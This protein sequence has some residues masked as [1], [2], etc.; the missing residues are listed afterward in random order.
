MKTTAIILLAGMSTR[1]NSS[2]NK[3]F[4]EINEKPLFSYCLDS[5]ESFNEINE[6]ILVVRKEDI[7]KI[8][9]TVR[10][11][12]YSKIRKIVEGGKTRQESSKNG[13]NYVDKSTD[14]VII[15]D[16]ARPL[17]SHELLHNLIKETKT[18]KAA[19]LALPCVD[20]IVS[21]NNGLTVT[22]T[23]DRTKLWSIQTP[24]AF[25][26]SLIMKAHENAFDNTASD[27]AQLVKNLGHDVALVK[28]SKYL[29]K[30]TTK[31]DI[32]LIKAFIEEMKK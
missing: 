15:H 32:P 21:S 5:F 3:Q 29:M 28:G 10:K 30:V 23:I 9:E 12:N 1:F 22:E 16:G 6:I 19:T 8:K 27:D 7:N 17:I 11:Y 13:L 2:I 20:T 18:Y 25:E 24:Q 31:E 26:L 4:F 14:L